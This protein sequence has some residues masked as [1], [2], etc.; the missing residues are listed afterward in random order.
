MAKRLNAA[1]VARAREL[2]GQGISFSKISDETGLSKNTVSRIGRADGVVLSPEQ[3]RARRFA[4][5]Y[6]K[7]TLTSEEMAERYKAGATLA[8]IGAA[9]GVTEISVRDRLQKI[10]VK[11]RTRDERRN[12]LV[13]SEELLEILDGLMLGDAHI[14]K[15]GSL[16]LNQRADRIEWLET[17]AVVL[18]QQS[19]DSVIEPARLDTKPHSIDGR[20]VRSQAQ[21]RFRTLNYVELLKERE[22]WYGA[23][24]VEPIWYK[25]LP[26]DVRMTP[27]A[28]AYWHCGDGS[29]LRNYS[30][31]AYN[32]VLFSTHGFTEAEVYTLAS[33]LASDYGFRPRVNKKKSRF[34]IFMNRIDEVAEFV[35]LVRPFMPDCFSYKLL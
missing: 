19:V 9:A 8:E 28:L 12:H 16:I 13:L 29:L 26:T 25:I 21:N 14:A 35:E 6:I 27:R 5:Q 31:G 10:G 23:V 11:R 24:P 32:R 20:I 22:R 2:I 4:A 30:R 34:V 18:K 3:I 7:A 17:L 1:A 15:T 33:R